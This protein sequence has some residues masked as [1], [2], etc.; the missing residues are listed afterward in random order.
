MG[1]QASTPAPPDYKPV[2]AASEKAAQ[3]G[4]DLGDK[5]L[6]EAKRQY[7]Q[8]MAT[9]Q[10]IIDSQ[11]KIAEQTAAQGQD[12][13]DYMKSAQ[14][15]IEGA[16]NEQVLRPD[17]S[18]ESTAERGLIS[19]S[20]AN[21]QNDSKYGAD[22][23]NEA[24][25]AGVDQM[26]GY[27]RALNIAARQGMRYGY[28][29][30]KMAAQTAGQAGT[31][32]SSIASATNAARNTATDRA[33]GLVSTGRNLRL[34]DENTGFARKMDAAGL[35]RGLPGASSG[36]YQTSIAAGNSAVNA[37]LNTGNSYLNGM[38]QGAGTQMAGAGARVA[39]ANTIA[40]MQQA[41]GNTQAE[42]SAANAG[43][44]NQV[45]GTGIGVAAVFI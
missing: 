34:Q 19:G 12:Y 32:A 40:G 17:S 5:Q 8:N 31:Q 16:I 28:S 36:A 18:P 2:A 3:L 10:P 15:P 43:S 11:T 23:A 44:T 26:S 35:Y 29:P 41:Y 20:N 13:Y 33:R 14:R 37:G 42:I 25:T 24:N 45:I 22:I 6:T 27:S 1:K 4:Y 30:A 39:G 7:D 21:L 9:A 38:N